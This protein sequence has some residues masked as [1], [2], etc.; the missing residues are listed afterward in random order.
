MTTN[1][2]S[3]QSAAEILVAQRITAHDAAAQLL[4]GGTVLL[5]TWFDLANLSQRRNRVVKVLPGG[6][7]ERTHCFRPSSMHLQLP[8]G[9]N[10]LAGDAAAYSY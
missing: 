6:P 1:W 2:Y 5:A 8:V 4:R 3:V 7:G 10:S 9:L